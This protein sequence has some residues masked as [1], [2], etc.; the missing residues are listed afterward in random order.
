MMYVS[1]ITLNLNSAVCP[2]Y[3]NKTEEKKET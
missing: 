2:L 3:P 1:L